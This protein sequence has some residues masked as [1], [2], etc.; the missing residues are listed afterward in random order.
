[1][2]PAGACPGSAAVLLALGVL[3]V[4]VNV[5]SAG[6]SPL[7]AQAPTQAFVI[8]PPPKPPFYAINLGIGVD[9]RRAAVR[10]GVRRCRARLAASRRCSAWR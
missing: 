8:W 4:I 7:V 9:A 3:F 1:M 2:T 10:H 5:R 6:R